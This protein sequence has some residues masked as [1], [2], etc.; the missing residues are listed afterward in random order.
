M[1]TRAVQSDVR[2]ALVPSLEAIAEARTRG[3][4]QVAADLADDRL[5]WLTGSDPARH[6]PLTALPTYKELLFSKSEWLCFVRDYLGR[7]QPMLG[8][9]AGRQ[10]ASCP[11]TV[12]ARGV[13]AWACEARKGLCTDFHHSTV[14]LFVAAI[15]AAGCTADATNLGGWLDPTPRDRTY[16]ADIV[17]RDLRERAV[18]LDV[19]FVNPFCATYFQSAL[20]GRLVSAR[21]RAKEKLAKYATYNSGGHPFVPLAGEFGG[22]VCDEWRDFLVLL[23]HRYGDTAACRQSGSPLE[24][25]RALF[26]KKWREIFACH[27]AKAHWLFLSATANTARGAALRFPRQF[28]HLSTACFDVG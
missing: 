10:C 7:V 18:L 28:G 25:A 16:L 11:G 12:D 15:N 4:A 22:G 13:H 21:A 23:S 8:P 3:D 20:K 9:F 24:E 5:R 17:V 27:M 19:T 14:A 26:L 1:L 2:R 6:L